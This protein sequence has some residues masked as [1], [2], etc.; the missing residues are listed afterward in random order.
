LKI[1]A[2]KKMTKKTKRTNK[3]R[4]AGAQTFSTISQH[5]VAGKVLRPPL[6][7]LE[8]V[9]LTSWQDD[10]LPSMVW[11]SLL[12]ETIPREDYLECF[13]K[14][15]A[16]CAPWFADDGLMGL[17]IHTP[18]GLGKISFSTL[19]FD[20]LSQLPDEQFRQFF[21]LIVAHPLGNNALRPLLRLGSPPGIDRWH[22]LITGASAEND[23]DLLAKAVARCLDHQSESSTDIRWLKLSVP[24]VARKLRFGPD[25]KEQVHQILE[26]PNRGDLRS[27]R[28][29]IRAAEVAIRRS[30]VPAWIKLFWDECVHSTTCIDPTDIRTELQRQ[31]SSLD[32]REVFGCRGDLSDRFFQVMS[33]E[34]VD[35]RLDAVFGL[36]LYALSVVTTLANTS[37][38]ETML[39]RLALRALVEARITLS[40]LAL[41]DEEKLW[42][43][44]RT[45]GAGQVKLAFLKIQES[46]GDLP[47]FC[48]AGEL[49][50]LANEDIWQEHLDIDL[51]HWTKGNLRWMAMQADAKEVYDKFYGWS[52][53]FVHA[54]WGAIR[55]TDYVTCHN[56][57]HRLHRIPRAIA[58][59]QPSV[60]S[61][62]VELLNTMIGTVEK[63]YPGQKL[64]RLLKP[65]V[66]TATDSP[67]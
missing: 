66:K 6:R 63:L 19:D 8:K 56:P 59:R 43:Q 32:A 46:T 14:L 29:S 22:A 33:S 28:P 37:T 1:Q 21:D 34:R 30:P 61:D 45:Y 23:W 39:G 49:E 52:S 48:S 57:L 62:A 67:T 54:Q 9:N 53:G 3:S 38:Q 51:G 7:K 26:Y 60:E 16:H 44:W 50:H 11:A 12:T 41:R 27:V 25:Y 47:S 17:R 5:E 20:T 40:F 64:I 10:H 31:P 55:D 13:R 58:R 42:D 18:S 65:I 15:I 24:I 4:P 36:T 2:G 35:P